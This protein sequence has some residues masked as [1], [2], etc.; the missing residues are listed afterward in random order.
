MGS[1]LVAMGLHIASIQ[2]ISADSIKQ[3]M[4]VMADFIQ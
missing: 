2:D 1:M 3:A 4:P